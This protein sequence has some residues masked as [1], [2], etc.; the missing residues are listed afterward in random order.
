MRLIPLKKNQTE[1]IYGIV[2]KGKQSVITFVRYFDD[3]EGTYCSEAL[4]EDVFLEEC[5]SIQLF[6]M[7]EKEFVKMRKEKIREKAKELFP[8][9]KVLYYEEVRTT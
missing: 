6:L 5:L 7:S 3:D 1:K 9:L 2:A 8:Y 4:F